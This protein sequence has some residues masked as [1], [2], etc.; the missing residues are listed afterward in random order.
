MY[1]NTNAHLQA[2]GLH[3]PQESLLVDFFFFQQPSPPHG[4]SLTPGLGTTHYSPA[5]LDPDYQTQTHVHKW[6]WRPPRGPQS[7]LPRAQEHRPGP[8]QTAQAAGER[9]WRGARSP[10]PQPASRDGAAPSPASRESPATPR[11]QP[12]PRAR[13]PQRAPGFRGPGE[14]TPGTQTWCRAV[15]PSTL[16]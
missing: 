9:L 1:T 14:G 15:S 3:L 2:S 11:P 5:R 4:L 8:P 12:R 13:A 7:I 16:A 6:P 10:A